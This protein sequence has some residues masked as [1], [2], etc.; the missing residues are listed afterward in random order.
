MAK[1]MVDK[2]FTPSLEISYWK[3]LA[4]KALANLKVFLGTL[5]KGNF[6]EDVENL[7]LTSNNKVYQ[8]IHPLENYKD[9]S[10][11]CYINILDVIKLPNKVHK[12]YKDF[13][14]D[15]S[16]DTKTVK[17][18]KAFTSA[19]ALTKANNKNAP[20]G[21]SYNVDDSKAMSFASCADA[22]KSLI[23]EG[24]EETERTLYKELAELTSNDQYEIPK[25][26]VILTDKKDSSKKFT[27]RL[28]WE[29]SKV[30]LFLNSQ[31]KTYY[32]FDNYACY[33]FCLCD[34][35]ENNELLEKIYIGE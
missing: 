35:F 1:M 9:T 16:G 8:L 22:F 20:S 18:S 10:K 31:S 34:S 23:M 27:A 26:N 6:E 30:A 32:A 29:S 21:K 28:Y 14:T 13:N 19:P 3:S 11:T 12:K 2:D 17:Q 24:E 33:C 5:S 25:K 4:I 15:N 7:S